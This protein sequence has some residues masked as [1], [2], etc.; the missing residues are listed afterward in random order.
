[1]KQMCNSILR[2]T[3]CVPILQKKVSFLSIPAPGA[4]SL[5]I[6]GK[7]WGVLLYPR[8]A[9]YKLITKKVAQRAFRQSQN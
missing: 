7:F 5:G 4:V 3:E 1:M 2:S 9:S 8:C 6:L